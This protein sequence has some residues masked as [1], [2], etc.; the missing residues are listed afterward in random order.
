M[1]KGKISAIVLAALLIVS[2]LLLVSCAKKDENSTG[3]SSSGLGE[4]VSEAVSDMA[5]G[6]MGTEEVSKENAENG[7]V[8]D[9]AEAS[10]NDQTAETESTTRRRNTTAA[11]YYQGK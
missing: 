6:I 7:H 10:S 11:P 1:F 4:K 8:T 2:A 5:D 9:T 3:S